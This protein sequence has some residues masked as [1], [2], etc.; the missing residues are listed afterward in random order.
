MTRVFPSVR[1]S[2][3]NTKLDILRF[4][5]RV[6]QSLVFCVVFGRFLLSFLAIVLSV[7][8]DLQ[9]L[10][11]TFGIFTLFLQQTDH[12][13]ASF[14]KLIIFLIPFSLRIK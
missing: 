10:I 6:A 5:V 13:R 1:T 12:H 11:T 2:V 7:F 3:A 8:F 14:N 4:L 9:L